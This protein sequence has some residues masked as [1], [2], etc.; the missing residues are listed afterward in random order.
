MTIRLYDT[1]TRSVRDFVPVEPGKASLYLCGVTVQGAPHIGH[2]RS[3]VNFDILSRWLTYRGFDV[4][5]C[6]NIT[7]I[8]DKILN[9]ANEAGTEYWRIAQHFEREVVAAYAIL[10]CRPPSVE[11]RATGH[12]PEMIALMRQLIETDHAYAANG[13]VYFDVRSYPA[14]GALSGQRPAEMQSAD[15]ADPKHAKRDPKD[16]TLWKGAKPGEPFWE[17][18]WGPGRPGWHLECSAMLRKYL[19][20]TVD[21]H[22]GG[23]D[24]IFPHHENEI[25]QSKSLGDE[26]ARYWLHNAWVTMANEKMSKSLGNSVL[27]TDMA[28]RHRPI[29]LRYY[30][31]TPHYRSTIEYSEDAIANAAVGFERIE[32]FLS[33]AFELAGPIEPTAVPDAFAAAMDDDLGVPQAVAVLHQ[34]VRAGNTALAAG[35]KDVAVGIVGELR[36]MLGVL[37]LDPLAEPWTEQG[38]GGQGAARL[39]TA[40]DGLIRLTLEQREAARKRRDFEASDAIRDQ[41]AAL[42]ITIEDTASGPRWSLD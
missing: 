1:A 13:D 4:T 22:G 28:K 33:R 6:R 31:G 37:G 19:G 24:L 18:P 30:L 40:V 21:I 38:A 16:F 17:T 12:I 25:A 7:D 36:A 5:F 15:D 34:A 42:G 3:G 2:V 27:V 14:Y 11:P 35:E 23:I 32:Q 41:L 8:D 39:R 10:G 9:K 29:V 20:T 26:F